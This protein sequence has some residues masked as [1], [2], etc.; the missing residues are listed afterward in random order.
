MIKLNKRRAFP[1]VLTWSLALFYIISG[2]PA[3]LAAPSSSQLESQTSDL[4]NKLND[5]NG[6]M[7]SLA[8]QL[9]ETSSSVEDLAAQV[10]QAKLDLAAAQA[11]ESLQ[12]DAMKD[13]I[14]F[15]YEGGNLSLLEILLS[16]ENMSDF[17]SKA[18]Y[19]RSISTYDRDMLKELKEVRQNV[20]KKQANLEKQQKELAQVQKDLKAKKEALTSQISS[21]S[22]ELSDYQAQLDRAK[23][24]EEALRIAKDQERLAQVQVSANEQ[25]SANVITNVDPVHANTDEV[26]LFAAVLEA[27]AGGNP[28]GL[29]AVATVIM[30]RVTSPKF[31]NTIPG[32]IYQ[33][34]Q[35]YPAGSGRLQQILDRGPSAIAYSTAQ[36]A[37]AGQ[38]HAAVANCYF[39][40][41]A[42]TGKQGINVGGNVFW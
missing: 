21:T 16:S 40:H 11:N 30:N 8:A 24:A 20:Q 39:F 18:E 27:E 17:L 3:V 4:Q 29:L 1:L 36:A 35:F 10:E 34:G 23:A 9:D 5:L 15:I 28:D 25:P 6:Q 41:A 13:R 2:I 26:A 42:W 14:K 38:R 7:S 12:Y 19:V 33:K 22:A 31:P 37:L 32:V